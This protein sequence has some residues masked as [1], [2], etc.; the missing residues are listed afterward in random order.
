MAGVGEGDASGTAAL[1]EPH[2]QVCFQRLD[3]AA[4]R[5]LTQVQP[6]GRPPEGE[7]LGDSDEGAKQ[8]RVHS[9]DGSVTRSDTGVEG[10]LQPTWHWLT[11]DGS[12]NR[13][14][15]QSRPPRFSKGLTP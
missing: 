12:L 2:A 8:T 3:L 14:P 9:G 10:K 7:F 15:C 1:Q 4:E 5:R 6:L 13:F 11:A